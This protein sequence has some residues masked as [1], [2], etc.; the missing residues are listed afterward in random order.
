MRIQVQASDDVLA[1]AMRSY[2][3]RRLRL[4]LGRYVGRL[5]QVSVRV[6]A[7]AEHNG[8]LDEGCR[9]TAELFPSGR[10]LQ[11]EVVDPCLFSAVDT[12]VERMA[13]SVRREV[14]QATLRPLPR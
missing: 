13:R 6:A 10:R 14:E 1:E 4:T 11:H 7:P 3:Q 9:I 8:R 2:I 12:A 5:L